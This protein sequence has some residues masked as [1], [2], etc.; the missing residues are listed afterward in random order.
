M[1]DEAAE[2]RKL[3]IQWNP[4]LIVLS[5]VVSFLGTYAASQVGIDITQEPGQSKAD[6]TFLIQVCCQSSLCVKGGAAYHGWNIL[7][8]ILFGLCAVWSRERIFE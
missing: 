2:L 7:A 4:T 8:A 1:P 3:V 6:A 5:W